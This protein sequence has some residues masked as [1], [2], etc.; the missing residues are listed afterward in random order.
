MYVGTLLCALLP[1]DFF[2]CAGLLRVMIQPIASGGVAAVW[3]E[4]CR[5]VCN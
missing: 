4:C 3:P 1:R 2:L 5:A